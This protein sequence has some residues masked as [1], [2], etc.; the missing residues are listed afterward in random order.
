MRSLAYVVFNCDRCPNDV[1]IGFTI[2]DLA[3]RSE[4]MIKFELERKGW[5]VS[6]KGECCAECLK[7]HNDSI[8]LLH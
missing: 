4:E 6:D 8:S 5:Y 3:T 1:V 7:K 2:K